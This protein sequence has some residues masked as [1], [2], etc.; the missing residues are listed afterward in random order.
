MPGIK[1]GDIVRGLSV[2]GAIGFSLIGWWGLGRADVAER[3]AN[4]LSSERSQAVARAIA[5]EDTLTQLHEQSQLAQTTLGRTRNRLR[6]LAWEQL[7][8]ASPLAMGLLREVDAGQQLPGLAAA[9][10]TAV[11]TSYLPHPLPTSL[12]THAIAATGDGDLL[13]LVDSDQR[14]HLWSPS[15]D[16]EAAVATLPG[17][18]AASAITSAGDVLLA[19]SYDG[20]L[21][22]CGDTEPEVIGRVSGAVHSLV[23]TS[24]G[25]IS[26]SAHGLI[27]RWPTE[28]EPSTL[29][30][31]PGVIS[32]MVAD[33]TGDHLLFTTADR[34][35]YLWDVDH[36]DDLVHL[37]TTGQPEHTLLCGTDAVPIVQ[38]RDQ[39]VTYRPSGDHLLPIPLATHSQ[40]VGISCGADNT[41]AVA[42]H[43]AIELWDLNTPTAPIDRLAVEMSIQQVS[44]LPD[45]RVRIGD[46]AGRQQVW[47]LAGKRRLM[48]IDVGTAAVDIAL[49]DDLGLVYVLDHRGRVRNLELRAAGGVAATTL[50]ATAEVT[51]TGFSADGQLLAVGQADAAIRVFR[52]D[53]RSVRTLTGHHGAVDVVAF[54]G[55]TNHLIAGSRDHR[56]SLWDMTT[57]EPT[58][59][60]LRGHQHP[61][62]AVALD[63][64][65]TLAATA[66]ED[67]VLRVWQTHDQTTS[68]LRTGGE[69]IHAL[70]ISPDAQWLV[71]GDTRG[72]VTLWPISRTLAAPQVLRG[73]TGG[74]ADI[75]FHPDGKLFATASNDGTVRLW[76]LDTP[77]DPRV[78]DHTGPVRALAFLDGGANLVATVEDASLWTWPTVRTGQPRIVRDVEAA[79]LASAQI[80]P[81]GQV[82]TRHPE[83]LR[84]WHLNPE[85]TLRQLWA[86]PIKCPTIAQRKQIL[87]D[88]D[89][90]AAQELER[91]QQRIHKPM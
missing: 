18:F 25:V 21:Y 22:R 53:D 35:T 76:Q 81:N 50:A 52:T 24:S 91:C 85:T 84:L 3:R 89:A 37:Q 87:G 49:A 60:F 73:H 12:P 54:S 15:S 4:Q 70:A 62:T 13:A 26:A 1:R 51:S 6:L 56:V 45:S 27:Q 29:T 36:P 31:V 28:G 33:E 75:V 46:G 34:A 17:K 41:V 11:H 38:R 78:L 39:V 32:W 5:A 57:A 16:S 58:P 59:Q 42:T 55:A 69:P 10:A 68:I 63:R 43:A 83:A 30:Q 9:A 7:D 47:D 82:V 74:I 90:T 61:I 67:G 79:S 2:I 40:I 48:D 64:D 72:V 88:D 66:S 20:A 77:D 65:A 14:V 86:L 80:S 44:P 23:H 71:S 19:G 8:P